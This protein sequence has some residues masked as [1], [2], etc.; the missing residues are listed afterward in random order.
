MITYIIIEHLTVEE[1]YNDNR[2]KIP[3]LFYADDGPLL[4]HASRYTTNIDS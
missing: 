1:C 4:T 2:V 3:A